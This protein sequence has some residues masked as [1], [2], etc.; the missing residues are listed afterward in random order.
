MKSTRTHDYLVIREKTYHIFERDFYHA[1]QV[2]FSQALTAKGLN[3]LYQ[4]HSANQSGNPS[5]TDL[6]V[7]SGMTINSYSKRI[8]P[9]IKA[10]YIVSLKDHADQRI[11]HV[12]LTERGMTQLND[13]LKLIDVLLNR[14]KTAFGSIGLL[15]YVQALIVSSNALSP[16]PKLHKWAFSPKR[17]RALATEALNRIYEGVSR[18]EHT[19]LNR[20]FET[21]TLKEARVILEIYTLSHWGKVTLSDL[22]DS[23]K[24]PKAT[25][26][27][28]VNKYAPKIIHK[29]TDKHD[30]R[31]VYLSVK[32][33]F[34]PGIEA[35]MGARIE[36]YQ[37]L[38]RMLSPKDFA[39][40]L[41]SFQIFKRLLQDTLDSAHPS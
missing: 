20:Y 17:Y 12:R 29:K 32:K 3:T 15:R 31:M 36:V 14:L 37:R 13:Y 1:V 38:E 33:T 40:I 19:V 2:G 7:N 5:I 21:F 35:W 18:A 23:L 26:S 4:I 9:L 22:Q 6:S 34:H 41:E 8:Q 30:H 10:G 16:S 25:L 24:I 11:H 39:R 27:R 28:I